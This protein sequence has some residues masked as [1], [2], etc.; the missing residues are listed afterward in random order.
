MFILTIFL[1]TY[2]ISFCD[3]STV[4]VEKCKQ[5][6]VSDEKFKYGCVCFQEMRSCKNS[7]IASQ[8]CPKDA[9][10]DNVFKNKTD[11]EM[12]YSE[13]TTAEE[14]SCKAG[15]CECFKTMIECFSQHKCLSNLSET[16]KKVRSIGIAA[17]FSGVI[18]E[19]FD[20]NPIELK[21]E[22]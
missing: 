11:C 16:N 15:M 2:L 8:T 7:L 13:C 9:T 10:A 5:V 22:D 1:F 17:G 18:E 19:N 4:D 6:F 14:N 12:M 21:E 3:S 20:E